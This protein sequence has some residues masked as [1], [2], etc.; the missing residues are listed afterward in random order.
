MVDLGL[1]NKGYTVVTLR[2][3]SFFSHR[4]V[5]SM[6]FQRHSI[7][8][9]KPTAVKFKIYDSEKLTFALLKEP[10]PVSCEILRVE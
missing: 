3:V 2:D 7:A 8:Y 9:I 10:L 5:M 6:Y 1:K 4:L